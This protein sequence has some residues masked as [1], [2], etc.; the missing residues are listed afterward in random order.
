MSDIDDTILAT[1]IRLEASIADLKSSTA[2]RIDRLEGGREET[3][4]ARS[5]RSFCRPA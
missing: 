2:T 5:Y 4:A 3:T 1:L